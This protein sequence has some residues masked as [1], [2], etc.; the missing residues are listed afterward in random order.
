MMPIRS[1][2]PIRAFRPGLAKK[3]ST[4][5]LYKTTATSA[6]STRNTS[7]RTRKIR[8]EDNLFSAISMAERGEEPEG[9][10]ISVDKEPVSRLTMAQRQL[11]KSGHR[12]LSWRDDGN[13]SGRPIHPPLLHAAMRPFYRKP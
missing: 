1:T 11:E 2:I 6:H 9:I 8:G 12:P 3:A 13:L 4:I 10:L 7:M 5:C